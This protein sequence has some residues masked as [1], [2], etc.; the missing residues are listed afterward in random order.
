MLKSD[1]CI[2]VA[3]ERSISYLGIVTICDLTLV[4]SLL[5]EAKPACKE[6]HPEDKD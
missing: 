6:A 2:F 3:A 1:E 4:E 5:R